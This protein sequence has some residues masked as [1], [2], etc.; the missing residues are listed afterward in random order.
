MGNSE[1]SPDETYGNFS[2]QEATPYEGH[3]ISTSARPES[4][5]HSRRSLHANHQHHHNQTGSSTN[6][7]YRKKKHPAHIADN[8]NSLDQ[9]INALREAGLES[10]NLILGID[11]TKSNEWTGKHSFNRRSL[12]AIGR[13]PN[14]YEQAINII[15]RTLS[16]FDEDNLIP[17]FGF[18]DSTTH[19]QRVFS[20]YPDHRPCNG[21]EEALARYK[22]ILPHLN[23]SGPTSFAPVIDAAVDIVEK[24]DFQYH[25]L[26]IIAD[27]QVTRSPDTAPGRL[28]PQEQATMNSIVAASEYPLSIILVG[29]GDGPWDAMQEFDDNIP[30]RAFDNFQFVNFTKIM[31][32]QKDAAKK[33]SSFA[34]AALMEIPL[35]YRATLTLQ[36]KEKYGSEPGRKPFPPPSGVIEHDNAMKALPHLKSFEPAESGSSAEQVCPI[37]LTNPKDM[38][39]GCGHLT[40]KDCG[41]SLSLCPLCRQP[42]TTR[43]RLY[44]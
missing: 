18:G 31:S 14:P 39:F 43:L 2:H 22:I 28:S 23:L 40:C 32:E 29:V 6:T 19:D 42:I 3:S 12:H 34:L 20:F 44:G 30:Q 15:G 17:C 26:V 13:T 36:Y 35:Q 37:C 10:S 25:V 24:S 9:V 4:P 21:F 1:S 5:E 41:V 8:F 33:E 11:F 7:N 27:G 16:P 38:A